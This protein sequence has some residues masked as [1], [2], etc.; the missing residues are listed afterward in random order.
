MHRRDF[1]KSLIGSAAAVPFITGS[2]VA[3]PPPPSISNHAFQVMPDLPVR[4]NNRIRAGGDYWIKVGTDGLTSRESLD[5][6]RR[7]DI[8][9]LTAKGGETVSA[10]ENAL[11]SRFGDFL[12]PDGPWSL[13][14]LKAM[15]DDCRAADMILEGIRMDSSYIAMKPGPERN[16]YL[17]I[18]CEN[19]R[20]ASQ[21]GV[22]LVSYHWTMIPIQ[23][24]RSM[25]GRGGSTYHGF[26][27]EDDYKDLPE[28]AVGRVS[29]DDYWSR[30]E[31]FLKR[32]VPVAREYGIRLACHPFDPGGLPLGYRGVDNWNAGDFV[33]AMYRY[34]S[35]VDD[36]HNGFTY[37]TAV[38]AGALDGNDQN[39][40]LLRT[41]CERGKVAQIHFRNIRGKRNDFMETYIDEGDIDMSD[42]VRVLRDTGWEGSLLPDHV[43]DVMDNP[44]DPRKL[45]SYAFAFGYIQGLISSVSREADM[46]L[47]SKAG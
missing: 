31:V 29:H 18:I 30:I 21:A 14:R 44:G 3:G 38:A 39:L 40:K 22:A 47:G 16:R 23:R 17:D 43:P 33:K 11:H 32:V 7:M 8:R 10:A 13:D 12:Q 28:T 35:I 1:T 15:Q 6:F 20:K 26:K 4:R 27:L 34:E 19:I 45:R 37:D 9:Y 36:V 42:C 46:L 24:N 2:A 5:Y 41:L 25:A